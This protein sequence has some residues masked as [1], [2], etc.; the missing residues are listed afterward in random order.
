[1][2]IDC[3][4]SIVC[5]YSGTGGLKKKLAGNFLSKRCRAD[6]TNYSPTTDSE[7]QSLVGGIVSLDTEDAP[8]THSDYPIDITG[9]TYPNMRFSMAEYSSRRIVDQFTLPCDTNIQYFILSCS[10]ISSRELLWTLSSISIK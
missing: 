7:A 6:D 5:Y 10:L 1:L 9:W 4:D 8:H 2:S 3:W